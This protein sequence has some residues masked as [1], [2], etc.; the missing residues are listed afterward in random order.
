MCIREGIKVDGT[1]Y[2][3]GDQH[4]P[5]NQIQDQELGTDPCECTCACT[6]PS[7]REELLA[8][9]HHEDDDTDDHE[10]VRRAEEFLFH[11]RQEPDVDKSSRREEHPHLGDPDLVIGPTAVTPE[12]PFKNRH[13]REDQVADDHC[14]WVTR[15]DRRCRVVVKTGDFALCGIDPESHAEYRPDHEGDP[16]KQQ[17]QSRDAA[18]CLPTIGAEQPD[19]EPDHDDEQDG[20]EDRTLDAV[21]RYPIPRKEREDI[22]RNGRGHHPRHGHRPLGL[23]GRRRVGREHEDGGSRGRKGYPAEC[24]G[25]D[26][27]DEG[28]VIRKVDIQTVQDPDDDRHDEEQ[29]GRS[30]CDTC[31]GPRVGLLDVFYHRGVLLGSAQI[32]SVNATF[33]NSRVLGEER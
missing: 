19:G 21:A 20:S 18:R 14:R 31:C 10:E 4:G 27:G 23:C 26:M 11:S 3:L 22:E 8:V 2:H 29:K 30:E 7:A 5:E 32:N 15:G 12:Q 33:W 17:T 1:A 28:V 6:L 24:S 25:V 9:A 16:R 13:G